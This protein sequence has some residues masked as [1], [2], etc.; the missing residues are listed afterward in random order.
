MTQPVGRVLALRALG[1][2]DLLTAVP[3][4]RGLRRAHPEQRLVLATPGWLEPVAML[5]GAVDGV[6]PTAPLSRVP[7]WPPRL[8]V[9]LHGRGPQS[10]QLLRELR[11]DEIWA[12]DTA[13]APA[14]D[15]GEHEVQRWC[16]L[17]E[18]H[19]VECDPLALDLAAPDEPPLAGGLTV[20]HPGGA[21][22]ARRWPASRWSVVAEAL[23]DAGHDVVVT[24][25]NDELD[26]ARAVAAGAGLAPDAVVAGRLDLTGLCAVV[27]CA[28]LVL[29]ADTGVAHLATA[30]RTPSLVLFG[31]VP[32]SR[33]GPPA[34]RRQHAVL[35]SG[36]TSDPFAAEPDPGLLLLTPD[37]VLAA[38]PV[39]VRS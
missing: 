27:A 3:A 13:G 1:L 26:L 39:P 19:G 30:Y 31:P 20:V 16:R 29:S 25:S 28:R 4:L 12:Y 7:G 32:P 38:L 8:A 34:V 18:A 35:W 5:T 6:L 11:A 36:T 15:D 10:T 33:W 21:A 17:L 22:A 2:G 23:A 9:N 14:W 24:G 37:D